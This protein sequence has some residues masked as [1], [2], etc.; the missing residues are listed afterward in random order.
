MPE[1]LPPMSDRPLSVG[2]RQTVAGSARPM[3]A[4]SAARLAHDASLDE[5]A[6]AATAG[7]VE[8]VGRLYD[9]LVGP[10]Y[11]YIALRVR[12]RSD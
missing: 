11:R 4:G 3:S 8:A 9:Q 1:S 12:R 10:I 5:L 7:D 2:L 6:R